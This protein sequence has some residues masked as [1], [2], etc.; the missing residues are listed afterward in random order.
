MSTRTSDPQEVGREVLGPIVA[1]FCLRLWSLG[2]AFERPGEAAFLFCARGGLRM[3]LAYERFLAA[4]ALPSAVHVAPLMVSRVVAMRPALS[5]TAEEGLDH[6]LPAAARTLGHEF[7]Q[8]SVAEVARAMSGA[9]PLGDD[10]QWQRPL[11]S[12]GLARLLRHADGEPVSEALRSQSAL[13]GRHLQESLDGRRQAVLVDTGL[14][15]TTALV[16]AEGLPQVSV[17]SALMANYFPPTRNER[18]PRTFGLTLEADGYSPLRPRS[19]LLRYWHLVEWLFEPALESVRWFEE[20]DG[21]VRSN[22]EVPG[23]QEKVPPEA[24]SAFAGVLS[25]LD[26]LPPAPA[27]KVVLDAETAWDRLH[28]AVVFPRAGDALALAVSDRTHDFGRDTTFSTRPWQ[29]PV[30]AL[31]GAAMWREG[32]IARSGTAFRVPLLALVQ[33]AYGAR[34]VKRALIRGS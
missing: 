21:V 24:G 31:R 30:A 20:T 6:L 25:Y 18:P 26:A 13:F 9:V 14:H 12:D 28:R 23:W 4:S 5:R 8:A 33:A 3:Q 16:L 34:R 22:L 7:G 15:G 11:T 19:V 1:E 27:E 17:S 2:A 32:E 29:G 10:L